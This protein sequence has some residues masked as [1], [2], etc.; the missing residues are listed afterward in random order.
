MLTVPPCCGSPPLPV[1]AGPALVPPAQAVNA[2]EAT[3]PAAR[4]TANLFLVIIGEPFP[5]FIARVVSM[6]HHLGAMCNVQL[7]E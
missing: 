4:A 2:S 5:R 1:C 7:H 3:A 6:K